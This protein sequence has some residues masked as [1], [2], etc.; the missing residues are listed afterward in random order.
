VKFPK[1]KNGKLIAFEGPF[2]F[3]KDDTYYLL[4]SAFG[5]AKITYLTSKN[6][7]GPFQY[8]G[9][10]MDF[11]P[12]LGSNNHSSVVK[13]K[14]KWL[15]FYHRHEKPCLRRVCVDELEIKNGKL[16]SVHRTNKGP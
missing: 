13:F 2:V 14:D 6:P 9:I 11:D 8:R 15:M 5:Y 4:V 3:K 12:K 7:L 16:Q 1:D 10:V